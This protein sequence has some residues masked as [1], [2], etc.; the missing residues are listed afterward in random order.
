MKVDAR[1]S[2][3]PT[4]RGFPVSR[5][6]LLKM[7]GAAALLP[8][9]MGLGSR[10]AAADVAAFQT[11]LTEFKA[12][13]LAKGI[14]QQTIDAAF[15]NV[16][17]PIEKVIQLDRSQPESRLTLSEYLT[18]VV[19][20][21]RI[22]KGRS[23]LV[24]HRALLDA[25]GTRFGVQ[26]RF[27]LS[28]WGIETDYG[29]VTGG[30]SVIGSLA[31]LAYE[32][33]RAEFFRGE[34]LHALKI[35]QEGHID[36]YNMT[37]SWAGAMGQSQ[38]MP[39]SFNAYAYDYDGDG[40]RDIWGTLPDVFASIANYLSSFSWRADQTWGREVRA[41]AGIDPNLISLDVTRT[42]QEWQALGVRN[43]DGSA[44]PDRPLAASLVFP[45]D[46]PRSFLVYG[47]FQTILKWNRSSYFGV[48]VGQLADG[49]GS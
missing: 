45:G 33:R 34:L 15:F 39:S 9:A 24:E 47:N 32:G 18:K 21:A 31:T 42:L 22:A 16:F 12:E 1:Q 28:L 2:S 38:F 8:V 41:P 7:A 37:G 4:S 27:I 36:P 13:A 3:L 25:V 43:L 46:G 35:V 26:P 11:W 17:G 20:P 6:S 10:V 49:I 40:R 30:Y 29:R 44:L 23:Y 5:R 14:S 19:S 48:A